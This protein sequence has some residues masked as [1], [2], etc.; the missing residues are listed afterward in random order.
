MGGGN[1][2]R[3]RKI[4][5]I[6]KLYNILRIDWFIVFGFSSKIIKIKWSY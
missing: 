2:T 6:I 4:S 1:H 5:Y 3:E